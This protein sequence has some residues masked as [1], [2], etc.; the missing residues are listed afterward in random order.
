M[1][2]SS[3]RGSWRGK[4]RVASAAETPVSCPF[5]NLTAERILWEEGPVVAVRDAY[6]VS[7]G[8]V[9][10]VTRRH[11]ASYFDA[12]APEKAALW[13]AIERARAELVA[14]LSPDGVNVGFNDGAAAGQTVM[15]LHVHVIPRFEGD[16]E[17][18]RG[19]VRGVI[20]EKQKYGDDG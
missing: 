20:P 17:D 6:P 13:R 1:A 9:L 8:H 19:G 10:L 5:C 4:I 14:E 2:D 11:V 15:H 3:G 16:V 7:R 12:T 18:P